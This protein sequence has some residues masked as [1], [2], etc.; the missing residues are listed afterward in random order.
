MVLGGVLHWTVASAH[1]TA[2][3]AVLQPAVGQRSPPGGQ[4]GRAAG[5]LILQD[6][7]SLWPHGTPLQ[8]V[9]LLQGMK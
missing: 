1:L 9:T 5:L 7:V 4:A 2:V 6:C 8:L 3:D